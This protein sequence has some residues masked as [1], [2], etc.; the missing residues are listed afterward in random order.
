VEFANTAKGGEPI[1]IDKT[2][3]EG[4]IKVQWVMADT[5]TKRPRYD[6][7]QGKILQVDEYAF[8]AVRLVRRDP[9]NGT[10][11]VSVPLQGDRTA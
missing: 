11:S 5:S 3:P 2:F 1:H 4:S 7:T 10:T 6:Y 8:G 9:S